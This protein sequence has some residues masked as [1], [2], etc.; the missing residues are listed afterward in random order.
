MGSKHEEGADTEGMATIRETAMDLVKAAVKAADPYAAV[1]RSVVR[2]GE[3]LRVGGKEY[4]LRRYRRILVLGA[5]KAS[6][7]MAVAL[8]EVLGERIAAGL[9]VVKYGYT[10]TTR[11]VALREAGHPVPDERGVDAARDLASMASQAEEDDLVILL[12][13]GGGSALLSLPAEGISLGDKQVVTDLLLRSGATIG[14]VNAVRKHLSQVKGG[15]LASLIYP[16]ESISLIVSDVIGDPLDVIAS[17][18]TV[19][20]PSTFEDALRVLELRGILDRMPPAVLAYLKRGHDGHIEDTPKPGDDVFGRNHQ[21]IVCSNR[22]AAEALVN[23]AREVGYDAL[24]LTAYLEGEA[25]EVGKVLAS[26]AREIALKCSPFARPVCVALGGETTVTVRGGGLGGR[27]QELVLSAAGMIDGLPGVAVVSFGTDGTDG[28]TNAAGAVADGGSCGRARR[29]GLNWR[30]YLENN[31]S[32]HFFEA[33]GDLIVTGPT[34]TNV[35]D[36][37]FILVEAT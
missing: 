6:A 29:L 23:R 7:P 22:I 35:N 8:E 24:L 37:S 10:A 17:G 9:V 27:N 20:D 16:A 28:P 30:D 32:Y 25:R 12:I 26:L 2:Q 11:I 18:P 3:T 34:N 13:S 31:D 36:I 33:L 14:E 15:R 4:D 19:P 21:Q 1:M 5:G